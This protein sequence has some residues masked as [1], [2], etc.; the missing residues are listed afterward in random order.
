MLETKWFMAILDKVRDQLSLAC[1]E[2]FESARYNMRRVVGELFMALFNG[3]DP[4]D[5]LRQ[6]R[7]EARKKSLG[8][9][10]DIDLDKTDV[11]IQKITY[12]VKDSAVHYMI[13]Y[14]M[15]G[16]L[17][18]VK[19]WRCF[20]DTLPIHDTFKHM[21]LR[22]IMV[23]FDTGHFWGLH[24]RVYRHIQR[25]YRNPLECFA[26]PF[27]HN[28]PTFY[29]LFPK[30]D[31][32]YGSVGSFFKDF[33][34]DDQHDFYV[35]NPPFTEDAMNK[36]FDLVSQKLH[37]RRHCECMLYV[38]KWDDLVVPWLE[39]LDYAQYEV[40]KRGESIVYDYLAARSRK[41]TFDTY[42]IY[43]NNTGKKDRRVL[44]K[45]TA[46]MNT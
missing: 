31:A 17:K 27:N 43:C 12:R 22:Y 35:V 36:T 28:L 33:L 7:H 41:A 26:S 10:A 38:P 45:A 39:S 21:M 23:G 29:S 4:I 25:H 1:G 8:M 16:E 14:I 34:Q 30:Y 18:T 5:A 9:L 37:G 40:L 24:P 3:T 44:E 42:I 6:F 19:V 46:I 32:P 2:E 13:T 20:P 15:D 11:S